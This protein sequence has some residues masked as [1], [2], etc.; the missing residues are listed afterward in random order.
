MSH[1]RLTVRQIYTL[2][3]FLRRVCAADPPAP[4]GR[5]PLSLHKLS[6]CRVLL[7]AFGMC[8]TCAM[9]NF[10]AP[11]G[12]RQ[13]PAIRET[14]LLHLEQLKASYYVGARQ[15]FLKDSS[16]SRTPRPATWPSR[17]TP[18]R[19][20]ADRSRQGGCGW[21]WGLGR[22]RA[23][24]ITAMGCAEPAQKQPC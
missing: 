5:T 3:N 21:G 10:P 19:S 13:S 17:P 7:P 22:A 8:V 6:M 9:P 1:F 12:C 2:H 4:S 24:P 18:G 11:P 14:E 23:G 15:P 16:R 20:A